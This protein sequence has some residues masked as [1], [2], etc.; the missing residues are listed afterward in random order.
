V[1]SIT[2]TFSID[3]LPVLENVKDGSPIK[4]KAEGR[5]DTKDGKAVVIDFSQ[6]DMESENQADKELKTLTRQDKF[7]ES[8][9]S[10]DSFF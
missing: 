7:E 3:D 2:L 4:L 10:G 6:F 5:V 1:P 9:K 8:A